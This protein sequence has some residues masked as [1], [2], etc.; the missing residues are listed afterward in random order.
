MTVPAFELFPD[1]DHD[2]RGDAAKMQADLAKLEKDL[3]KPPPPAAGPADSAETPAVPP[4]PLSGRRRRERLGTPGNVAD[5]RRLYGKKSLA[6]AGQGDG[7]D[8]DAPVVGHDLD[9]LA[10]GLAAGLKQRLADERADLGI[11]AGKQVE[12]AMGKALKEQAEDFK[13]QLAEQAEDFEHR[14]AAHEEE[15]R[16]L[17]DK[18][19][20][21]HAREVAWLH[22]MVRDLEDHQ[23]A[24]HRQ[25]VELLAER[26]PTMVLPPDSIKI[27]VGQAPV[28]VKLPARKVVKSI[29][30]DPGTGRPVA[31]EETESDT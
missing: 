17:I 24:A 1:P 21:Q 20:D 22:G 31:V 16:R 6:D 3:A 26:M 5:L 28:E 11:E 2:A 19:E 30:Y 13:R 15:T 10:E 8:L 27:E 23:E 18:A 12:R 4:T 7:I 14:L 29:R 25:T 9:A